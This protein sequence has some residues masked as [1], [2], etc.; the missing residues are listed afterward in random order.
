[1]SDLSLEDQNF[2]SAQTELIAQI[3]DDGNDYAGDIILQVRPA[4]IR[5]ARNEHYSPLH[6][7]TAI[8]GTGNIYNGDGVGVE[9]IGGEIGSGGIGIG[10]RGIG[11]GGGVGV[12]GEGGNGGV[13]VKGH[14]ADDDGVQGQSDKENKSG[15]YG[16]N[17][18]TSG[19]S[20]GVAGRCDSV[21]G[22]G[23]FGISSNGNGVYGQCDTDGSSGVGRSGVYGF[24][25]TKIDSSYGVSGRCDAPN[26]A[27]VFGISAG[28]VGVHGKSENNNPD[29]PSGSAFGVFG[30]CDSTLAAGV[31]GNSISGEGVR[32]ASISNIG[33]RGY[34]KYNDGVS[35]RSEGV[36]H[37]GVHGEN[38]AKPGKEAIKGTPTSIVGVSG[39]ADFGIGVFGSG[40]YGG[41]F[42]GKH[43]PVR[44]VPSTSEGPPTNG[45][46][47]RGELYVD[48]PGN[49][50]FCGGDGTPGTWFRVSLIPV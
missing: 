34:S 26:G 4:L 30:E 41:V 35:G 48:N 32:G 49:L 18:M 27:G 22:A 5:D 17:S 47:Q 40:T 2:D 10:V 7:M 20:Y 50:F 33:V 24:N 8:Q 37:S 14:S 23:V 19:S 12:L 46:H 28:G 15:V 38:T 25:S 42:D 39:K 31:F 3:D 21:D 36:G 44:L 43:A 9:G 45:F 13:G 11:V 1:M 6:G 29:T 16:F